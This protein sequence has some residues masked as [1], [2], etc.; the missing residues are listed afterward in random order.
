L[1]TAIAASM[2]TIG[3]RSAQANGTWVG[4]VVSFP[5]PYRYWT[6]P[7]NWNGGVLP[8]VGDALYFGTNGDGS[9]DLGGVVRSNPSVTFGDWVTYT[10][11]GAA[12]ST[13]QLTGN[14][15]PQITVG[16]TVQATYGSNYFANG[17]V[18]ATNLDL[19]SV[20]GTTINFTGVNGGVLNL[21]GAISG[22]SSPL[23]INEASSLGTGDVYFGNAN[24]GY[25]GLV[26]INS[27]T[28]ARL[29][30]GGRTGVGSVQLNGGNFDILS[31]TGAQVM[32]NT[33]NSSSGTVFA[34]LNYADAVIPAPAPTTHL[35]GPVTVDNIGG[36]AASI[37]FQADNDFNFES[38]GGL[39][40]LNVD[41][42]AAPT[43]TVDVENGNLRTGIDG[44]TLQTGP[45][46]LNQVVVT[47]QV[48]SLFD[49][50]PLGALQL[51]KTGGGVLAIGG[52]N[53]T[54]SEGAK[55]VYG[56]T[57]RFLTSNSYGTTTG[58]AAGP[59][60]TV[61]LE[62]TAAGAGTPVGAAMGIGYADPFGVPSNLAT[63]GTVPGQSGAFDVDVAGGDPWPV[64]LSINNTA[65]AATSL[66]LGSSGVGVLNGV[67]TPYTTAAG[68]STFYLGGGGGSLTINSALNAPG[69]MANTSAEMG[70]TGK[71]LPGEV[72][73]TAAIGYTGATNI[74]AGTLHI[75]NNAILTPSSGTYLGTYSTLLTTGASYANAPAGTP[76]NGPGQLLL[77]SAGGFAGYN[78]G[79]AG[80]FGTAGLVLDGGAVGYDGSIALPAIPYASFG[81]LIQSELYQ[82]DSA[83]LAPVGTHILHLGGENS[84]GTM[85]V[86]FRIK[87]IG[88]VPL[89]LLKSGINST[90]DLTSEP[91]ANTAT[92]GTGIMGGTV[93]VNASTQLSEAAI[94]ITDGG[95]LHIVAIPAG[96]GVVAFNQILRVANGPQRRGSIVSVDAGVTAAFDSAAL[97]ADAEQSVLEKTGG[98]TLDLLPTFLYPSSDPSNTWGLKMDSGLVEINQLPG[99][100]TPANGEAIF[101]ATSSGTILHLVAPTSSGGIPIPA[102]TQYSPNYGFSAISTYAGTSS[103]LNIDQG[104]FFRVNGYNPSNLMGSLTVNMGANSVFKVS[105]SAAGG[106]L[107]TSGTGSVDFSGG[108]VQFT[109]VGTQWLL[110]QDGAFSLHL[111]GTPSN[112]ILFSGCPNSDING[113]LYFNDDSGSSAVALDGATVDNTPTSTASTWTVGGTGLTSWN[114]KV[115]KESTQAVP[116]GGGPFTTGTVVIDRSAGAPVSVASGSLLQV[117]AGTFIA[118]GGTDPFT[119]N[120]TASVTYGNHVAVVNNAAFKVLGVNA[121]I[122][123]IT[124]TGTLTVGNGVTANTLQLAHNS[125]ASSQNS[126]SIVGSS[127][128]D[129]VNNHMYIN[130]GAGPDPI[131]T[132][133]AYIK[134]GYNG[135]AW[136]GP[137]IISSEA[138]TNPSGLIYGVGYADGADGVVAGLTSGQIEIKYTLMGD[139]N[140]D[141]LVNSADFNIL[142]ANF[143]QSVTGWD[144]GD[145]NYDGLVNSADFNLLAAN[146]N[147]GDVDADVSVGDV[148][149]L[150][151]FA[152]ANGLSLP[153]SIVPEPASASILV[154]ACIGFLAARRARRRPTE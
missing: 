145:F 36:P 39:Y 85:T 46:N 55:F 30:D 107:D 93:K 86:T 70:T 66:R 102:T 137:G 61:T 16:N 112:E 144:Q 14:V 53:Q 129:I 9:V 23:T 154:T 41:G 19:E 5:P 117:D 24:A 11:T 132:I 20:G 64:L 79:L 1:A 125:G 116:G 90:L 75:P 150:D 13:L 52:N 34:D 146:F 81:P 63:A 31:S 119:D 133:A 109:P 118:T 136:N 91:G 94:V 121:T 74:Y 110:P 43:R 25:A 50:N 108:N 4:G 122:Q 97:E 42:F 113:N 27:G 35:L 49:L 48:D 44:S 17:N 151:T 141:G 105:G 131:T 80:S 139:A 32:A 76:F 78:Y 140:L 72:T 71:L 68:L 96:P 147:Q 12:G 120:N 33:I 59:R 2:A 127:T 98:G 143:N 103:D 60:V 54:T 62:P 3:V 56:G 65:G 73:L 99:I 6:N 58:L 87:D 7:N 95:I 148:A 114:G 22:A 8:G 123:G 29:L 69:I 57:L 126:L 77:S 153:T 10:L 26:T 83:P 92:G 67:V 45:N 40:L 15:S 88:G 101:A 51:T 115:F 38:A 130:Y 18:I 106:G 28:A 124:G 89:A 111:N 128:L 84:T 149:A 100:A 47:A 37:T 142:A 104:A 134:S 135:G 152:A 138:L 21:S 82:S